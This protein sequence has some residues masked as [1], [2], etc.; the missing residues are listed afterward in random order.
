MIP[1]DWLGLTANIV[2]CILNAK[3]KLSCWPVWII[4]NGIWITHWVRQ[5]EVAAI[6]LD[7]IYIALNFY[8]YYCWKN[9]EKPLTKW[10]H[11]LD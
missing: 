9:T 2:G 5:G 10:D 4:G 3:Q 11:L 6:V 7:I 1:L 8:G